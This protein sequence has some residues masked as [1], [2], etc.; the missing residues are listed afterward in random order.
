MCET[1]NG[2]H[3]ET[4]DSPSKVLMVSNNEFSKVKMEGCVCL[5]VEEDNGGLVKALDICHFFFFSFLKFLSHVKEKTTP[6]IL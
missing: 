2:E 4:T 1:A 3:K 6:Q 5:W